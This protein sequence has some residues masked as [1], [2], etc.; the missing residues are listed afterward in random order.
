MKVCGVW[1]NTTLCAAR[2]AATF[3]RSA[4]TEKRG[5]IKEPQ[6]RSTKRNYIFVH[7]VA[8]VNMTAKGSQTAGGSQ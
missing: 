8:C 3:S 7:G 5:R 4:T 2:I 1:V 6:T